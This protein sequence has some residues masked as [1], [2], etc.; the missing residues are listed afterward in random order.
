MN[1]R[2]HLGK[3]WVVPLDRVTRRPPSR[4]HANRPS[5]RAKAHRLE[6]LL[7]RQPRAKVIQEETLSFRNPVP[8]ISLLE[9]RMDR[10]KSFQ[11]TTTFLHSLLNELDP[12]KSHP[13]P[14]PMENKTQATVRRAEI[15]HRF[16]R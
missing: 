8:E 13:R 12:H 2:D 7:N 16:V 10:T 5:S 9:V 14:V 4:H 6:Y 1:G 15:D 11:C 3:P